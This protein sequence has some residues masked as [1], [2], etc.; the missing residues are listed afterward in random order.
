MNPLH[1]PIAP[2]TWGFNLNFADVVIPNRAP[3]LNLGWL[4]GYRKLYYSFFKKPDP[5]PGP[6]DEDFFDYS[7]KSQCT[8][9]YL[10]NY[11]DI[12]TNVLDIGFNPEAIANLLGTLYFLLEVND[13]NKNQSEVFRSNTELKFNLET[14]FSYS[15]F[16]V[17]ARIPNSAEHFNLIFEASSH[18]IFKTRRYFGPVRLSKLKIRLLDENGVVI[19]LNNTDIVINLEIESLNSPYKNQNFTR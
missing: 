2:L 7:Y 10:S 17:L 19:N 15:V 14:K 16:N 11:I 13:Y 4:L 18:K 9:G 1:V 5:N 12:S 3:F 8:D 6:C